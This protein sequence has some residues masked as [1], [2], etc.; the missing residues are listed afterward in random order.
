M[1]HERN[2]R[3]LRRIGV[4]DPLRLVI[5]NYP[6]DGAEE[7]FAPNHPQKPEFGR[8]ALP[9]SRDLLIERDDFAENPPKGYFRL[10]PG[11]EVRLRYAYIIRCTGFEKD[12]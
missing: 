8:R 10:T 7:C 1:R 11:A 3:A 2:D 6:A 4:P 9:F 5:D 12:A